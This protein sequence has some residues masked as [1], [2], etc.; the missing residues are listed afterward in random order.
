[1]TWSQLGPRLGAG[2]AVLSDDGT[3]PSLPPAEPLVVRD[4][5]SVWAFVAVAL[6]G[7]IVT[8]AVAVA[9]GR[10]RWGT[11][12][13]GTAPRHSWHHDRRNP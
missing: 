10:L 1:M 4:E 11:R 12:G 8:L 7:A 6:L 9:S 3:T 5:V 2:L 13:P